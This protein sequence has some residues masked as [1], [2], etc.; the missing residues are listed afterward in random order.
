MTQI[1]KHTIPPTDVRSWVHYA[2]DFTSGVG[3][4]VYMAHKPIPK[5]AIT[6]EIEATFWSHVDRSGEC[7]VWT[8]S[9]T[10]GRGRFSFKRVCVF[11]PRFSWVLHNSEIPDGLFVCHHCDNPACVRPDHLFLGTPKQNTRDAMAKGRMRLDEQRAFGA[12]V[13]RDRT[14]CKN[15]H[16]YAKGDFSWQHRGNTHKR[17]CK[18]CIRERY[19]ARKIRGKP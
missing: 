15:G 11:A 18:A 13:W 19:Y 14:H 6:P 2:S 7:W 10:R 16:E 1:T 4:R 9:N 17:V 5:S 8:A 3:G 12:K